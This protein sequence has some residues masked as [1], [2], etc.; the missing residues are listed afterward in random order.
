MQRFVLVL[1]AAAATVGLAALALRGAARAVERVEASDT[2]STGSAMQKA[3]YFLLLCL[4]LYVSFS[5]GS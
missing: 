1:I 4:I 2:L 3:A 5:G